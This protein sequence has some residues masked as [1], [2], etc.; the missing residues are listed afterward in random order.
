MERFMSFVIDQLRCYS[1]Y[2]LRVR[3]LTSGDHGVVHC[4]K[5]SICAGRLTLPRHCLWAANSHTACDRARFMR[6]FI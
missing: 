5:T 6:P 2:T 1:K 4:S 3:S